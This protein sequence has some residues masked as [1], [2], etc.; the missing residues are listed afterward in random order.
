MTKSKKPSL[1]PEDVARIIEK[2]TG[3]NA[4]EFARRM[5]VNEAVVRKY[6]REGINVEAIAWAFRA[7]DNQ[8]SLLG[9]QNP[10]G[11]SE[12]D[13]GLL[14][15]IAVVIA[16]IGINQARMMLIGAKLENADISGLPEITRASLLRLNSY[17]GIELKS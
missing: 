17:H 16:M 4:S 3:G 1:P 7:I 5:G 11:A 13:K 8:P 15:A 9:G 2:V 10:P 6:T 14:T 12:F